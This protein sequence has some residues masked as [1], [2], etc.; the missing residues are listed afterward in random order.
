MRKLYIVL[1]F[2]SVVTLQAQNQNRLF[3]KAKIYYNSHTDIEYLIRNGVDIDHI[4]NHKESN[5]LVSDFSEKD[6][7]NA[8]RL[9]F[10]VEVLIEDVQ[11]YYKNQNKPNH[12]DYV[13]RT[14]KNPTCSGNPT[15]NYTTPTN[16]DV[17]PGNQFGGFYTYAEVLQELDDM[18]TQYPNLITVRADLKDPAN[19]D[20]LKTQEGRY[21]QWVKISDNA[22][23][24]ESESQILYT[25]IHHAREPASL[26]QLIF[27]MWY[28]LENYNTNAQVKSIVDNTELYFIPVVNPD[29]YIYNETTDPQGGGMWRKNRKNNGDGSFGVDLNRNYSYITPAGNEVF[30]GAGTSTDTSSDVYHGTAPFSE[31]ETQAVRYFVENHNF[32]LALNNHT[33]G[34]L[35]LFPFGY[36]SNKPTPDNNVF[37]TISDIM[38]DQNNFT[39]YISS[40]LYPAAGDSDDFMYGMLTTESGGTRE[41]VFAMTPEIGSSFWPAAS[42]IEGICKNMVFLNLTA[43]EYANNKGK[44]TDTS[45]STI[46]SQSSSFTYSL[47][48]LG[49]GNDTNFT[50][51]INPVSSNITSVGAAVS[52]NN[53]TL[54][55][56]V[57]GSID[58]NLAS[59]VSGGDDI[60]FDVLVN[61]GL[62]T[63]TT[64]VEKKYGSI[65]IVLDD[66]GNTV[67]NWTT[68]TWGVSTSEFV[69]PSSSITDSPTGNY[70]NNANA[71]I[72]LGNAVN[73]NN[74]TS[75]K[76]VYQAKWDIEQSY[77]YVQLQVSID[78]GSNWIPQCA[79]STTLGG[80]NQSGATNEPIYD[81][82][83]N[84]TLQTV[85]LSDYLNQTILIRFVLVTDNS[86]TRDGFYFDDLQIETTSDVLSTN[87]YAEG[88]FSIYP[89][90]VKDNLNIKALNITE[91]VNITI[92]NMLGQLISSKR[93]VQPNTKVDFSAYTTGVYILNIT[94]N[95]KKQSFRI[96]K[97]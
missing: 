24:D 61:N 44:F 26:Q 13:A 16:Y 36:A 96:I 94:T 85:D 69:S 72:T 92:Y 78:N 35:L 32:K 57:D 15:I 6:I 17:K 19:V 83:S 55:Q 64:R 88:A 49:F 2:L 87:T 21:I 71:T 3:H 76:L 74:V 89:N 14:T 93:N 18:A 31:P 37:E 40:S 82:T 25:A 30:G 90:P 75:A 59:N 62:Y 45:P 95:S 60:V 46:A 47:Q 73:L 63:E 27:Y 56:T 53:L 8:R 70:G 1:L 10:K 80:N 43:A 12:K 50:V 48:R 86:E 51:S 7:A 38:V 81:G 66:N 34:N 39:N 52:H 33:H 54:L 5:F 22:N 79:T 20:R 41:K 9:G 28:L 29:G 65:S 77:D 4:H 58:I 68:S 97:E 11:S 67:N 84:W 91:P 23:T 42:Q